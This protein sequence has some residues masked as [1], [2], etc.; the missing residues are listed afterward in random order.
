[1]AKSP[2]HLSSPS[3]TLSEITYGI[4]TSTVT[5]AVALFAS[6]PGVIFHK[7]QK[8]Y[9]HYTCSPHYPIDEAI[10]WKYFYTL[11]MNIVGLIVPMIVMIFSYSQILKTLRRCRNEKKQKAVRLIFVIMIFYFIFW[12]PFNI[13]SFLYTFQVSLSLSTCEIHGQLVKA[14]QVTEAISMIHCCINPVIYAFVGEKFRKYLYAFFRKHVAA[15]LCKN[16]PSLYREKLE[17][18]SSTFTPSTAEHDI[19]TGL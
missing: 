7:S 3:K 16:C 18:V 12:T 5:W 2:F 1:M 13:A 10:N 11:M 19:S 6:V 4:L 9:S 15:H 17:R 8:E 14:V